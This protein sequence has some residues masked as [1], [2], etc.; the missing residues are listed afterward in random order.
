ME[1]SKYNFRKDIVKRESKK[2]IKIDKSNEI[3]IRFH[4]FCHR[5]EVNYLRIDVFTFMLMVKR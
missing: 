3:M 5:N 4:R 2:F 1:N